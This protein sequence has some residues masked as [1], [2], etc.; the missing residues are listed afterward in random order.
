MKENNRNY[1]YLVRCA[2]GTF[3]CGWTND[4]DGRIRAHNAGRGAR[5]TR[6][7]LPVRL[8]Y[9]EEF[10]TR[11]EAMSREAAIKKLSRRDKEALVA[12]ACGFTPQTDTSS[13]SGRSF[14][15]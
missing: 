11:A 12:G 7:R 10:P 13:Y 8:I 15:P 9:W 1:T 3:Y 14:R 2:D 6:S 5:Y 4:L